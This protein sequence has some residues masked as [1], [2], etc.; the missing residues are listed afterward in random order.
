MSADFPLLD[1]DI[2]AT[3]PT[4][5]NPSPYTVQNGIGTVTDQDGPAT[6]T[7]QRYGGPNGNTGVAVDYTDFFKLF[8]VW[9]FN[10]NGPDGKTTIYYP[11]ALTVWSVNF[12]GTAGQKVPPY[13]APPIN[14][15]QVPNGV[16]S[17]GANNYNATNEVPGQ[18]VVSAQTIANG[19]LGWAPA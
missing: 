11:I 2:S 1:V 17:A 14:F 9:Q 16:N 13:Q 12:Y 5:S 18:M 15:I 3:T 7:P 4:F 19:N 10:N 8:L 6:G